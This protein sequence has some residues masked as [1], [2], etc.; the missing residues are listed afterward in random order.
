LRAK[1]FCLF[2]SCI[3]VAFLITS[4]SEPAPRI[5]PKV[6]LTASSDILSV[7]QGT[8]GSI[9]IDIS[10]IDTKALLL[11]VISQSPENKDTT[12]NVELSLATPNEFLHCGEPLK[13][14]LICIDDGLETTFDLENIEIKFTVPG[15]HPIGTWEISIDVT[16]WDRATPTSNSLRDS[17]IVFK[18]LTVTE[19]IQLNKPNINIQ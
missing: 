15:N 7:I 12:Q 10:G 17:F 18:T 3:I 4:C 5:P 8:E 9:F 14:Y 1:S 2:I 11:T 13:L 19:A 6:Y 16:V